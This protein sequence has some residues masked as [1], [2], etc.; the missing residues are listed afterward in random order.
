MRRWLALALGLTACVPQTFVASP[1]EYAA[2]RATR[3]APT[4]EARLAAAHSYL[5]DYPE[6]WYKAQVR[7]FFEPAEEAFFAVESGTKEGLRAYLA[8][9]PRGPHREQARRRVEQ[10]ELAERVNREQVERDVAAVEARVS[11]AAVRE[12]AEV[13]KAFDGWLARLL[14]AAVYDAP[15]SAADA[16]LVVPFALSLPSPRCT[17]FDPPDGGIARRCV[18]LLAL[19]YTVQTEHG[20][21]PREATLEI[22]LAEDPRGV[23]LEA[24]LAGPDLFSRLEE[25]HR[26][27]PLP[28]DDTALRAQAVSRAVDAARLTF[29]RAVLDRPSCR[30]KPSA[31]AVL[32]LACGGVRLTAIPGT[33]PGEDD[34]LEIRP[35]A[36]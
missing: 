1:S 31:P 2:Y 25:T 29:T 36:P 27:K 10:I 11:D 26:V 23:P 12:R 17:F 16:A 18:K 8:T 9:L 34:R 24:F 32:D 3:V 5:L 35:L 28:A 21:E 19:P 13:Q 6:G 14:D 22:T 4:F 30:R 15:L 7:A 33:K 20:L